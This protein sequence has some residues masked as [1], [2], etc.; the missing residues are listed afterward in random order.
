MKHLLALRDYWTPTKLYNIAR[1]EIEKRF[2]VTHTRAMPYTAT[3]DVTNACNLRC[4]GCPTG[5]GIV[6]RKKTM[7]DLHHLQ[8]F[9]DQAGP[10]LVI[11]HLY[12]WG[13]SL[14]HPQAV[15]I[16][17][18]IHDWRIFTSISSNLNIKDFSKIKAVCDAG[19]DHLIISADGAT[20]DSYRKYRVG[21]D[22]ELVLENIR[23]IVAYRKEC[24]RRRPI[25]EWKLLA[26]PCCC[27]LRTAHRM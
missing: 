20:S 5:I 14:L 24:G 6:G 26:F 10:Y 7:M 21:G 16:V 27:S 15:A 2:R 1:C 8:I 19:L 4:P 22:F 11:A 12:N 13:E 17:K 18:M 25:L 23:R 9:L 3:I